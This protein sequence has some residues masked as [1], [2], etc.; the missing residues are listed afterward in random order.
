MDMIKGIVKVDNRTKNLVKRLQ[1]N[2]IAVINHD[3]LDEVAAQSLVA[4]K[5]KAVINATKSMSSRYPNMGPQVLAEAGVHIVDNVGVEIMEDL[6]DG[7][8]V[9]IYYNIITKNGKHIGQ[10]E[11]LTLDKINVEMAETRK[12]LSDVLSKFVKNT[13]EYAQ[14]EQW[15]ILGGV[16]IPDTSIKFKDRHTLIVVRGQNYKDDLMAIQSYINEVHPILVGVDG[17]ADALREFGYKPD[18]IIGD[19]D[20]ITDETL[21]CGS[22]IIVHAYSDGRAPGMDRIKQL[23]LQAITFPAPGTSE[24]IA[25]L[26]AYEK[27]TELIV[28]VG[29]HSNMIDFLEKGRSGMASTF[30]VRMKV[31]SILVDARGV[32]KLYKQPVRLRSV[33]AITVAAL[34]PFVLVLTISPTTRQVLQLIWMKFRVMFRL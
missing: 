26:L 31:G 3:E 10:G 24:D 15:F 25:M 4:A 2:E 20:S 1:P 16:D 7:D 12:N 32:N 33:V 9:E 17:G 11:V 22:E 28:A 21:K 8:D 23:G 6:K 13:L 34:I 27:G 30:L 19:M 14:Q 5:V 29:T 18:I